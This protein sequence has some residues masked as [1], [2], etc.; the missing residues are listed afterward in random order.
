MVTY[1][2]SSSNLNLVLFNA[3][4]TMY[5]SIYSIPIML[6]WIGCVLSVLTFCVHASVIGIS[7][8]SHIAGFML[9]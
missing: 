5:I 4:A 8:K 2:N 3:A 7:V 6:H 9:L 1:N